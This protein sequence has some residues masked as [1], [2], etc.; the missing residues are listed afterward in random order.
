MHPLALRAASQI[1]TLEIPRG[2][3][4]MTKLITAAAAFA[5]FAPLAVAI[6]LQAAQI[7]A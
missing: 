1:Q 4:K 3:T 5:L 7:V 2:N 6:L